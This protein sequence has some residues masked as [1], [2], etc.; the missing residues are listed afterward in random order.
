MTLMLGLYK[1]LI[2]DK[3]K[4]KKIALHTFFLRFPLAVERYPFSNYAIIDISL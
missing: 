1:R 2:F 3:L 4:Q